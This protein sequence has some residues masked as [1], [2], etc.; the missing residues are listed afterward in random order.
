[1][2]FKKAFHLQYL[3]SHNYHLDMYLKDFTNFSFYPRSAI[4]RTGDKLLVE[5][6]DEAIQCALCQ[7][8]IDTE[9]VKAKDCSALEATNFSKLVSDR[10]PIGLSNETLAIEALGALSLEQKV[11][12][13][14]DSSCSGEG[15]CSDGVTGSCGSRCSSDENPDYS[16]IVCYSCSYVLKTHKAIPNSLDKS[17]QKVQRHKAMKDEIKDF[18][19]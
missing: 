3:V 9:N 4:F 5:G 18:L 2:G 7:G 15:M 12:E 8:F 11:E 6:P 17:L 1:M 10:G 13:N 14:G 19:L 16:K